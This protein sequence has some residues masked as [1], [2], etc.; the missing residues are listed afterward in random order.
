[1]DTNSEGQ[2]A[3]RRGG[4]ARAWRVCGRTLRVVAGLALTMTGIAMLVAGALYLRLLQGPIVLPGLA[5]FAAEQINAA[6]DD[7][8]VSAADAIV[9]LGEGDTPS[10]L[11]FRDVEVRSAEGQLL[12]AAPRIAARFYLSDLLQGQIQPVRIRLIEPELQIIR[13]EDGQLR[14]GLGKGDGIAVQTGGASGNAQDLVARV[15]DG[16]VGDAPPVP[17]LEKLERIAIVR[18]R[19]DYDDRQGRG[20]LQI[21]EATL[22]LARHEGGATATMEVDAGAPGTPGPTM[23]LVADRATGSGRTDLQFRFGRIAAAELARQTPQLDWLDLIGGTVEGEVTATLERD[24]R[25]S[26]LEGTIV[27]EDGTIRGIGQPAPF[28]VAQLRFRVD[29]DRE[30]LLV[31]DFRLSSAAIDASVTGYADLRRGARGALVGLEGQY[32]IG[33]LHINMPS[34]FADPLDFDDGGLTARWL[35]DQERIDLV[36]VRLARGDLAFT[37]DGQ[38]RGFADGWVADL[39]AA[40]EG[41][42]VDD[43][44]AFWPLASARSARSWI[45]EHIPVG[46]IDRLSAQMRLGRGDPQI[47]LDFDFSGL[48]TEYVPGMS[49]IEEASGNGHVTFNGLHLAVDAGHVTPL[50]G[51]PIEIG[52]STVAITEFWKTTTPADITLRA[53]GPVASVL[54]LIDEPP[55]GLVSKLGQDLSEIG[56]TAR[57]KAEMQFPLVS[58]LKIEEVA[59][60]AEATLSDVALPFAL[61]PGRS[62][63]L[64][65]D[66]LEL[67]ADTESLRLSGGARADGA[68][69]AIDWRENYGRGQDGRVLTLSGEATPEL[70]AAAGVTDLPIDGT[71]QIDLTLTQSGGGPLEFKLEADLTPVRL[72]IAALDWSK[73]RGVPARLE[74]E[75]SQGD[76]L[77]IR[78][79]SLDSPG[80]DATGSVRLAGDGVLQQ[81]DFRQIRMAGLGTF[82][83]S[84]APAAD[85]VLEVRLSG[86]PLDLSGRIEDAGQGGGGAAD[87]VRLSLDLSELRLTEKVALS[88]ARGQIAQ[89]SDGGLSGRLEGQIGGQAPVA[90]ELDMPTSGPGEVTVTSPNA[91]EALYAAGLYSGAQGGTLTATVRTGTA[92]GAGLSGQARIEDVVVHSQSTFRDVLRDGGLSEAEA[93]IAAGGLRF[94]EV[95]IPFAYA[96]D[97]LTLT[98]AIAVSPMLAIKVNGTIDEGTDQLDLVGVLSPAYVLTGALN[99]VPLIGQI[100][101]GKGEGI[102][103]M[104]F[105]VRGDADDPRFSVNPLSV[106]APGFLR[107]V[108]TEPGQ[109]PSEEFQERITRQGR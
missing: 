71:P 36:G 53:E 73:A 54:A 43:L 32:D 47:A 80:L 62:V 96:G 81:A 97:Q 103:A 67:A 6:S 44:V 98:D 4:P 82:A 69:L 106:L 99:E 86:G 2:P 83:A 78:A 72:E 95:Q 56:G 102:L 60:Q 101:G 12:A 74:A 26:D 105:R 70:L 3:A 24:G 37:V 28:D 17:G 85:G 61:E 58:D 88:P 7:L 42:T 10:G 59:V 90:I 66:R 30:R 39:R 94:R 25:L 18:A 40:A 9:S 8:R 34:V 19:V 104:T 13:A 68:P 79:L 33:A 23:R 16:F 27:A 87:P 55:L 52:G 89:G 45:D 63:D 75:G 77:D 31:D 109:G 14:F 35:F 11:R 41:M 64:R 100:L 50:A 76:G 46:R 107:K 22:R 21:D 84:A 93:E 29:R 1:M 65:A 38:A 51:Q 49:P 20:G 108:F 15:I 92:D 57:V 5:T 48:R 91:G